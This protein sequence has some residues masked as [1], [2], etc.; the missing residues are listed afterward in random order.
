MAGKKTSRGFTLIELVIVIAVI[1]ILAALLVPV[2]LN[3]VDKAKATSERQSIGELAKA[4]RRFKAETALW[5]YD[6][7]TWPV[8]TDV[9]PEAFSFT[10]TA[11]FVPVTPA[12]PSCNL[13]TPGTQ[14]WG[15]PY[16]A[17]PT[18]TTAINPALVDAW[19]RPRLFV[20]IRP[21][22]G[23]GGGTPG[24]PNGFVAVW[25]RGQD[26][27]DSY[28][29]SDASCTRDLDRMARG[30]TSATT[31]ANQT[32]VPDDIVMVAGGAR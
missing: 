30:L 3:Q 29:C 27:L 12:L 2:I 26:G 10:D 14:C 23:F 5:P 11:L 21:L 24:A 22:D 9:Y 4:L 16:I 17:A 1:A 19:G 8:T 20:M 18:I 25:S 32:G 15:G 6:N 31:A 7:S 28:G 13:T